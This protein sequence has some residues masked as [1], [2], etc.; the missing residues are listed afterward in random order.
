MERAFRGIHA[1]LLALAEKYFPLLVELRV[2]FRADEGVRAQWRAAARR[3]HEREMRPRLG[4]ILADDA[5]LELVEGRHLPEEAHDLLRPR[6]VAEPAEVEEA[7][8]FLDAR[9]RIVVDDELQRGGVVEVE[10]G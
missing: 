2:E 7:A 5:V 1:V 3:T 10:N 4:V 8:D 6:A 9:D